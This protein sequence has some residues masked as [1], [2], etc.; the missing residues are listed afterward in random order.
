MAKNY[1]LIPDE[2]S[3]WEVAIFLLID[4][5]YPNI[6][7]G[8]SFSRSTL[9]TSIPALTFIEKLLGSINYEVSKTLENSISSAITRI[10]RAD[11]IHCL[12][13]QCK[14]TKT[15]SERLIEIRAKYAEASQVPV[16]KTK[17]LHD[18]IEA[19]RNSMSE[20]DFKALMAKF[21]KRAQENE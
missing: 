5:L 9:C 2:N 7:V 1:K 14:L 10:D 11:F 4:H 17:K 8:H 13:H 16:G 3:N 15:G 19:L 18:N 6:G 20:E 12:D 21:L